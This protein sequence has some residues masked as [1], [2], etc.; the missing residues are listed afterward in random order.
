[1]QLRLRDNFIAGIIVILPVAVTLW[2]LIAAKDA[3]NDAVLNPL[4]KYIKPYITNVYIEYGV[5]AALLFVLVLFVYLIGLAT[6][7]LFVRKLFSSGEA[8]F[9]KI[10][11]I[12]KVYVTMKQMSRAFLGERRGIFKKPV[13]VEYPRKGVYSI[14]FLTS[15][16][17]GEIQEKTEKRLVNIFIP[18]TPNPTSGIL[19]LVPEEEAINLDM[20]VEEAMKLIISGGVVTPLTLAEN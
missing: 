6:R 4:L 3:I 7:I 9:F 16:S 1:M 13:L 17:K 14:G 19:L 8:I 12:G 5:K 2:I 20:S 18:T 11:M 15:E 10:P